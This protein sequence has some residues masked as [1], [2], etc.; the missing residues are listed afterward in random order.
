MGTGKLAWRVA[1]GTGWGF[2]YVMG[3]GVFAFSLVSGLVR[4]ERRVTG[5]GGAVKGAFGTLNA[6]KAS[7]T[8]LDMP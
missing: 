6:V 5:I 4:C 8:A 3:G 2:R 1:P 7:F